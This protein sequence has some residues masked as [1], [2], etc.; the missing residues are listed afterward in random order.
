M[1]A[2]DPIGE[3]S[4]GEP[5]PSARP[6]NGRRIAVL[7]H[8]EIDRL[9]GMI[10]AQ[11]ALTLRCPLVRIAD[12]PDPAPVL[13]WL[14]RFVAAP[15]D[16]LILMTGEGLRRLRGFADRAGLDEAFRDA[17]GRVRSITR[18]PK[19]AQ[20]LREIGLTPGLRAE[21]PTSEGVIALLAQGALRGRRIAVQLYPEAPATL[22]DFLKDRGAYPDP[23]WPYAYLPAAGGAEV[24]RLIEEMAAGQ[25]DAIAFTSAAQIVQLFEMARGAGAE[26][27]LRAALDCTRIA[28]IGPVVAA[29][30]ER[31]GL[32]A[33]IMPRDTYFMKPL[34]SA[35]AAALAEDSGGVITGG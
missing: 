30:L 35:I 28:A 1:T 4:I 13:A 2:P 21:R 15:P 27:R 18:G 32:S 11:G 24:P 16:D 19:P 34:V 23:V 14:S 26:P 5:P 10:E 9:G 3:G 8:R 20:A 7:E 17:L 22:V 29:E 6:L 33:L 25:V 12:A 31:R